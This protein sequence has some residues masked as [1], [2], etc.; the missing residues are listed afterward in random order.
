[1]SS[2][3]DFDCLHPSIVT[4]L[5]N[6]NL[7]RPTHIQADVFEF[8]PHYF[9][10]LVA[11][12]TGSG[13][14]LAFAAPIL[15]ELE[16]IKARLAMPRLPQC[17][18]GLILTPTRE[19][20]Q[21]IE[22]NITFALETVNAGK[23]PIDQLKVTCIIGGMS[24]EKQIRVLQQQKPQIVIGTAGRL[25]ELLGEEVI[26]FSRLKYLV[27]DEADRMIEM[28]HFKEIDEILENIF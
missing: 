27:I 2:W 4:A 8:Y 18:L 21:Q 5:T 10:F 28:G 17:L 26:D 12:Q 19:L 3:N 14:T 20:A 16:K 1:M 24:K 6:H 9:D 7:L 25:H 11:A 22:K 23:S 13:K 15:S